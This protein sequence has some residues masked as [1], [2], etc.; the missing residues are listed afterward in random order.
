MPNFYIIT[1]YLL[2]GITEECTGRLNTIAG[3]DKEGRKCFTNLCEELEAR[4]ANGEI[5]D[6]TVDY[7]S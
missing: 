2:D 7:E 1:V 5:R 6:Y 3:P 4:L